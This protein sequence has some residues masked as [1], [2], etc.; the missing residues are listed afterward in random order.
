MYL[1]VYLGG[2]CGISNACTCGD[3]V[4]CD[5]YYDYRAISSTQHRQYIRCTVCNG[6]SFITS[7]QSHTFSGNTCTL[8]GYTTSSIGGGDTGGDTSCSHGSY[9]YSYDYYNTSYH[10]YTKACRYCSEEISSSLQSHSWQYSYSAYSSSQHKV[11]ATCSGCGYSTTSYA[12]HSDSDGDGKC[13]ACGTSMGVTV[14]WNASANGGT[15][16][17]SSSVS[18]TV[19]SGSVAAAPSYTPVKTGYT[20]K[21]WYTSSN[22]G[23]LYNTV[24]VTAARTFYAQFTATNYTITW[25][26]GDGTTSTTSQA[27]GSNL[28]LPGTPVRAGYTFDGWYTASSGGTQV[29]NSTV[30]ATASASTYY[31]HWTAKSY[32]ITWDL[33]DGRTE[34]TSQTYGEKLTLPSTPT[35]TGYAFDG[36]FTAETGGTQVTSS[37]SYTTASNTT[38]YAQ[39]TGNTYT[40]TWDLGDGTTETTNQVYGEKLVLPAVTPTK[41]GHTFSGWYTAETGGSKV[42]GDTVYT[43]ASG[44]TY[45]AQFT[46]NQYT[47]I[48]NLGDG[49]TEATSQTYGENLA[50]P[51][52]PIRDGYTFLGWYT[53]ESGGTQVTGD[54]VYTATTTSTFYAQWELIPVFSVTVPVVMPLA[55]AEDGTVH[56]A[57]DLE[58]QNASTGDVV[59]TAVTVTTAN[60]WTLVPFTTD[61][62]R[63]KVDARLVGFSL[64]G[65]ETTIRGSAQDLALTGDWT[66]QKDGALALEYGAVLSAL[67]QPVTEQAILSVVFVLQWA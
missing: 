5:W 31:A 59:V 26:H 2:E 44:T 57:D 45:Y 11:T 63:E 39:W 60:G 7:D 42:T 28:V 19:A 17:G 49:R 24:T 53:A 55:V 67:S 47:I 18:T 25:D 35:R 21:G 52:M 13:D 33:G 6:A 51:A 37:T 16:N 29:T 3:D 48:W 9:T 54:T 62:A 66:V 4:T 38:Y 15:V 12:A 22:G 34:T 46:P 30:Y 61:M 10:T 1:A 58:I 36:W 65:M 23:S 41:T 40:I 50:L 14:T 56:T 20:F 27:Y 32:T 64:N 43:T 8:C